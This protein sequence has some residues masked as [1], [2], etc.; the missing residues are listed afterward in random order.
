MVSAWATPRSG[1]LPS[2][3]QCP[4]T[5]ATDDG[6]L[7]MRHD[8]AGGGGD[9]QGRADAGH[10]LDGNARGAQRGQLLGQAP[11]DG[12]TAALEAHHA[13]AAPRAVDEQPM[14]LGLGHLHAVADLADT[15]PL[16]AGRSEGKRFPCPVGRRARSRSSMRSRAFRVRS[17]GSPGPAPTR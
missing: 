9:G 6:D 4:A 12:R 7:P 17:P 3:A 2:V 1:C 5:M 13:A 14:D 10:H 11:E 8:D 16:R 15:D